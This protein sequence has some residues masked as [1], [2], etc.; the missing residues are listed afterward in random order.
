LYI[1]IFSTNE[2]IEQVK[3]VVVYAI[4]IWENSG[5]AE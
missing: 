1:Y 2:L 5:R 4:T 3:L